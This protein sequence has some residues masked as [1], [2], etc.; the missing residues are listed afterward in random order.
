MSNG[1]LNFGSFLDGAMRG[2]EYGMDM[3]EKYDIY[4]KRRTDRKD[5]AAAR[6]KMAEENPPPPAAP[7]GVPTTG[8]AAAAATPAP[9][10]ASTAQT[11]TSS[12]L[13]AGVYDERMYGTNDILAPVAALRRGAGAQP[14]PYVPDDPS[15]QRFR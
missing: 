3:R 15:I 10:A 5:E 8:P 2:V 6:A 13:G 1:A 11:A 4:K 9:P 7:G 14:N 12:R